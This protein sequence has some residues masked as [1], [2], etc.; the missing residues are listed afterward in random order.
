M[1]LFP[2]PLFIV[3]KIFLLLSFFIIGGT[4]NHLILWDLRPH[5]ITG[6]KMEKLCEAAH[7]SINKNAIAGDRNALFPGRWGGAISVC[8]DPL[9][10]VCVCMYVCM[11]GEGRAG[12]GG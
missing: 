3:L 12:G 1:F 6:S 11:R 7:I 2:F 9:L 10:C 5:G 4:D 8:A